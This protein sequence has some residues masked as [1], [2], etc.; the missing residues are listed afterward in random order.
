MMVI[1]KATGHA[2][3]VLHFTDFGIMIA[4]AN[5]DIKKIRFEDATLV[6]DEYQTRLEK[7]AAHIIGGFSTT[8]AHVTAINR[9]AMAKDALSIAHALIKA[10]DNDH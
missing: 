5:G 1:D 10:I 7:I 2:A 8:L 9:D 4:F 3:R 6:H